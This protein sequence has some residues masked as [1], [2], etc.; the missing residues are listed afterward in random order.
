MALLNYIGQGTYSVVENV[1]INKSGKTVRWSVLVF[2]D[3]D[4]KVLL[5]STD[6]E[7]MGGH[8]LRGI[9]GFRNEP[10][11]KPV[12]GEAWI[13][14]KSGKE[15]TWSN[16]GGTVAVYLPNEH[17]YFGWGFW[18]VNPNE[19]YYLEPEDRYVKV[20]CE[21]WE[22]YTVH[23]TSDSRLWDTFF[24]EDKLLQSSNIYRQI[25]MCMKKSFPGFASCIDA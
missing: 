23:P 20:N 25:Y 3:K 15:S 18:Y 10:S 19:T 1:N 6:F 12:D 5:A 2:A 9:K 22:F 14:P 4:K 17:P 21:S 8:I 11:D 7:I 13:V 16:R 24:P